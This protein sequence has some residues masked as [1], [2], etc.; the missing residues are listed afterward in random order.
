MAGIYIHTP[1]C[2]TRCNYCDFYSTVQSELTDDFINA[3]CI[4]LQNRKDYINN[5]AVETIYFGGGTPSQLSIIQLDKIFN[6][7]SKHYSFASD[8]EITLEA[9]PDDLSLNYLKEL[10]H[11]PINR[12]SIGIQTF[13]DEMLTKLNR[14]HNAKQAKEAVKNAQDYGFH[15]LSIDLMYG[16]PNET[17]QEWENDLK[18][19]ILLDP[20][21]ISAYHLIYEKGTKLYNYLKKGYVKEVDEEISLQFFKKLIDYLTNSN[22]EHYEIS[23]FAKKSKYAK[24]NTSYWLGKTYLGCGP[25]AHSYNT[26][27]RDYNNVSL[28]K[29]IDTM[30]LNKSCITT[31][32]LSLETQYNDYII[33]GLRTRWGV[34][35]NNIKINFGNKLHTYALNMAQKH[36]KNGHLIVNKDHLILSK[37][38]IFIS[39][40]IMSD[41][42]F[43]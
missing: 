36:I 26:K 34:S 39:D 22:Y 41:L 32:E 12:L 2:K 11:L 18:E 24:H 10:T 40:G 8:M 17:L 43:V 15:N 33:T 5:E 6:T 42:I 7:I 21:H 16:L 1:F 31:E 28:K 3:L 9:N 13:N 29:Y 25:S 37:Q 35:L 38:G 19:A 23:N 14:R 4:E 20:E 27:T 30:R